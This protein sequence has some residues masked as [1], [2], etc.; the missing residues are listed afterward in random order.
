M[1]ERAAAAWLLLVALG[2]L[3]GLL[4]AVVALG[5]ARHVRR[6][7]RSETRRRPGPAGDRTDDVEHPG[8]F[9]RHDRGSED[10][11]P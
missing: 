2:L 10:E 11:D 6:S 1:Q 8:G 5:V 4:V 9:S 7:R 3:L